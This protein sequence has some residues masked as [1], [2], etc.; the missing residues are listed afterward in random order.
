[1]FQ[2]KT[3]TPLGAFGQESRG[4]GSEVCLFELWSHLSRLYS[5]PSPIAT[6]QSRPLPP[7]SRSGPGQVAARVAKAPASVITLDH[8]RS[9]TNSPFNDLAP[10]RVPTHRLESSPIL[11]IYGNSGND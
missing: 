7:P 1:M 10:S 8:V 11:C 4:F 3:A 9:F 2:H 5:P 6:E